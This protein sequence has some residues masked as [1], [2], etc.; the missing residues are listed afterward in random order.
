MADPSAALVAVEDLSV[1]DACLCVSRGF[2][3]ALNSS[4]VILLGSSC[5]H[6]QVFQ[7]PWFP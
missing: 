6:D 5:W 3:Q 4:A 1:I 7:M 2:A